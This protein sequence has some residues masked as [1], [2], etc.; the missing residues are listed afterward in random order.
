M[1][2]R[3]HQGDDP[4]YVSGGKRGLQLY[5]AHRVPT[6]TGG[7]GGEKFYSKYLFYDPKA[8]SIKAMINYSWDGASI[9]KW[10]QWLV[11]K[12]R[13]TQLAS[14]PHDLNYQLARNG[15]WHGVKDARKRIDQ[16]FYRDMRAE[17][18]SWLKAKTMYR[19]VR[20]GGGKKGSWQKR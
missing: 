9:P 14:L 4:N 10:A 18:I 2:T 3:A 7:N 17:G 15:V 11:R 5:E 20:L 16:Q 6:L 13:K 8:G 1:T 12:D 19:A